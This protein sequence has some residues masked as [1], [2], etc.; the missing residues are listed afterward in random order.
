MVLGYFFTAIGE[1]FGIESQMMVHAVYA[2]VRS[3]C[4]LQSRVPRVEYIMA[5]FTFWAVSVCCFMLPSQEILA[6]SR[7][8]NVSMARLRA[9]TNFGHCRGARCDVDT[10]GRHARRQLDG[11]EITFSQ[12]R[13]SSSRRGFVI[14]LVMVF[15]S[16]AS[17]RPRRPLHAVM[18]MT[19]ARPPRYAASNP[20]GV[21][22]F[23]EPAFFFSTRPREYGSGGQGFERIYVGSLTYSDSM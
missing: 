18:G 23:G 11:L 22:D 4:F 5:C 9:T 3:G 13:L 17:S 19:S 10:F 8:S 16:R 2:I 15:A 20:F 14:M 1:V 21:S 12:F 6:L 7:S